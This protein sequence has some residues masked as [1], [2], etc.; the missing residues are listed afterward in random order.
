[1]T[2]GQ[3]QKAGF[4]S[5]SRKLWNILRSLCCA[6]G[7]WIAQRCIVSGCPPEWL[8]LGMLRSQVVDARPCFVSLAGFGALARP[9]LSRR[10]GF[11]LGLCAGPSAFY[12]W[13]RSPFLS[14][15]MTS[16]GRQIRRIV[17]GT[18][19]ILWYAGPDFR[20]ARPNWYIEMRSRPCGG[21]CLN[22]WQRASGLAHPSVTGLYGKTR[23]F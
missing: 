10:I 12:F 11:G 18:A 21:Q 2:L 8:T 16:F 6:Y 13:A 17:L 5:N 14:C 1:M 7:V 22:L 23:A 19:W 9:V 20:K 3:E 4:Q 15:R